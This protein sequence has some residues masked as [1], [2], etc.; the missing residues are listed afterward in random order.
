MRIKASV[1][2][3]NK[4][5]KPSSHFLLFARMNYGWKRSWM[6][7]FF[8]SI[9][10]HVS[11]KRA[12]INEY[13]KSLHCRNVRNRHMHICTW[14][15]SVSAKALSVSIFL[16]FSVY[17][18]LYVYNSR[19]RVHRSTVNCITTKASRAVSTSQC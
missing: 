6:L 4:E 16:S 13:S 1:R 5:R 3:K 17:A 14:S 8:H 2:R 15:S 10:I 7:H 9:T 12:N 18:R 11:K 19:S